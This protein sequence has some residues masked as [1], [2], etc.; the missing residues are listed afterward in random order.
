M[1]NLDTRSVVFNITIVN[2]I[3]LGLT[4][5]APRFGIDLYS[6]LGLH[7]FASPLFKPIQL[8]SYM[9]MHGGFWHLFSN[10]ITLL[11]FGSMLERYWGAQRFLLFY[12]LTGFGAEFLHMAVNAFEV[13]NY[14]GSI[15]A[16]PEQLGNIYAVQSIYFAPTVGASGAVFGILAGAL[17][18]FPNTPIIA[19]PLPIQLEL[20]YVASFY[21][22][23]ELYR[24]IQQEP[25][26]FVAHFAHLG[27]AIMGYFIIKWWNRD[28]RFLF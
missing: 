7:Y 18:L 24:A 26:D 22:I 5:I 2:L 25:G 13:Y 17:M 20:K 11:I 16:T 4:F 14:C 19:F 27:G 6:F 8:V 12:F 9:F 3:F 15:L 1:F 28:N 21:L 10:T 23:M